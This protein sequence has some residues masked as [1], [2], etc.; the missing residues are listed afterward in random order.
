M[1]EQKTISIGTDSSGGF[2][3][4]EDVGAKTSITQ[5]LDNIK[6]PDLI[7]EAEIFKN[8]YIYYVQANQELLDFL[9]SVRKQKPAV[10]LKRI[11][12]D[13]NA[14][15]SKHNISLDESITKAFIEEAL[16]MIKKNQG[17][18]LHARL[19]Q[20]CN[21]ENGFHKKFIGDLERDINMLIDKNNSP[22]IKSARLLEVVLNKE[23]SVDSD[24]TPSNVP[25]YR[26]SIDNSPR[27]CGNCKFFASEGGIDGNCNYYKFVAQANHICDAW[28]G[29]LT[30]AKA[31]IITQDNP[32]PRAGV[33][34]AADV[35]MEIEPDDT[36]LLL[37]RDIIYQAENTP[38]LRA[39]TEEIVP[40][41]VVYSKALRTFGI[42]QNI[43]TIDNIKYYQLKLIDSAG[44]VTGS[45][46]A[47][48]TDLQIRSKSA[49]KTN[50][51]IAAQVDTDV[52][53]VLNETKDIFNK[54]KE[55]V[56]TH[57]NL[58][59]APLTNSETITPLQIY[60]TESL[61]KSVWSNVKT[62][63]KRKYWRAV[64]TALSSVGAARQI[65]FEGY[66][67]VQ[68]LNKSN[69]KDLNNKVQ[70]V[71]QKAQQDAYERLKAAL[72]SVEDALTLPSA[73]SGK[74]IDEEN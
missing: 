71:T 32:A 64:Q 69:I 44:K 61:T 46:F 28:Q 55:Y 67:V 49:F 73:T 52:S 47:P 39:A 53:D 51:G 68:Q 13:M 54:I 17:I 72:K 36:E 8:T 18:T 66:K 57:G 50:L 4:P 24:G 45:G 38:G 33:V 37:N 12:E 74:N 60:I 21:R 20:L 62:G 56:D 7:S 14:L 22:D 19:E 6:D 42:V 41:D 15:D 70:I 34:P 2:A 40:D 30:T 59:T 26:V 9:D 43:A 27:V 29:G 31:D 48:Q 25:N 65:L 35:L 63:P 1:E 23:K 11:L 3:V 16:D 10:E 58:S 5:D